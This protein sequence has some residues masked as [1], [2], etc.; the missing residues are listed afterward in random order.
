MSRE[1]EKNRFQQIL[2]MIKMEKITIVKRPDWKPMRH[3]RQLI[4]RQD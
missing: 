2:I 1:E 4:E 3:P